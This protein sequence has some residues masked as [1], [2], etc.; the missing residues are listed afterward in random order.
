MTTVKK[1][2]R[3][4]TKV[5]ESSCVGQKRMASGT[6][7]SG[8]IG[9]RTSNGGKRRRF[10]VALVA[11]SSPNGMPTSIAKANPHMTRPKLRYQ[12]LQKPPVATSSKSRSTTSDGAGRAPTSG[13]CGPTHSSSL[14]TTCQSAMK[15]T[16]PSAP[17]RPAGPVS[18][19]LS[20]LRLSPHH[21]T[22]IIGA[23]T[24]CPTRASRAP[25]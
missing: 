7:A 23:C 17:R 5:I 21:V 25:W 9:R 15:A 12:L 10:A 14:V 11:M 2:P 1:A 8:G 6:Q 13:T 16:T 3:K 20:F 22:G 4:V 24:D 19:F 18:A